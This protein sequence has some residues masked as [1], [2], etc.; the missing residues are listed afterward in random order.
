MDEPYWWGAKSP[1]GSSCWIR[2]S[3]RPISYASQ[4]NGNLPPYDGEG[5]EKNCILAWSFFLL[6]FIILAFNFP[7]HGAWFYYYGSFIFIIPKWA[8]S[9]AIR[10]R[11]DVS[12]HNI[13]VCDANTDKNGS[14]KVYKSKI[15]RKGLAVELPL[16]E[17]GRPRDYKAE[18]RSLKTSLRE[19]LTS[20][21][22]AT[23]HRTADKRKSGVWKTMGIRKQRVAVY[24][25]DFAPPPTKPKIIYQ[26]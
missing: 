12:C 9:S 6:V 26:I 22:K 23:P 17:W 14:S 2:S 10:N 7:I 18:V 1:L 20:S 25:F 24:T 5:N 8:S 15:L 19:K 11:Y 4:A 21:H 13:L 16:S 3:L